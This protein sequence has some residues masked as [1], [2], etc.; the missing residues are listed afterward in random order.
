[1]K[2]IINKIELKIFY[3]IKD[4]NEYEQGQEPEAKKQ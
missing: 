3:L 2:N 1:M 4:K